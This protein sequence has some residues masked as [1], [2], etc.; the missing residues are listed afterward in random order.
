MNLTFA[1]MS[2]PLFGSNSQRYTFKTD[3]QNTVPVNT[4]I[5][6]DDHFGKVMGHSKSG[7]LIVRPLFEHKD[8]PNKYKVGETIP[9]APFVNYVLE[10]KIQHSKSQKPVCLVSIQPSNKGVLTGDFQVINQQSK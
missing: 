2:R 7:R 5:Q 9:A 4:I 1:A 6:S 3:M 8:I 10:A